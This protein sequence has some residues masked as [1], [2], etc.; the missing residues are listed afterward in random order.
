[1]TTIIPPDRRNS[2]AEARFVE[3]G[4]RALVQSDG[5][6]RVVSDTLHGKYYVVT[7]AGYGDKV[8]FRCEPRGADDHRIGH[9]ALVGDPGVVPCLHAAGAARRLEREGLIRWTRFG[10]SPVMV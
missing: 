8:I 6:V 1:M 3:G 7:F 10:W 2:E 9:M 5:S 4:H